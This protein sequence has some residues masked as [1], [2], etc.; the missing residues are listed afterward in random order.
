LPGVYAW[1]YRN[2]QEWLQGHQPEP[3]PKELD[4]QT[5]VNWATRDDVLF[6]EVKE[7]VERLKIRSNPLIHVSVTAVGRELGV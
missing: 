6:A 5:R 1:L 7:A 3:R 2:G 4:Y